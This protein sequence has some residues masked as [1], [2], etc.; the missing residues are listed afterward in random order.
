MNEIEVHRKMLLDALRSLVEIADSTA[1]TVNTGM[2]D[3][4]IAKARTV[5]A[6]VDQYPN[7]V[8]IEPV[9]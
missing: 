7:P 8:D 2:M 9:T 4:E 5:I 3:D 1:H 6:K